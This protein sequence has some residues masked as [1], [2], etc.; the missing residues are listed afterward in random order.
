MLTLPEHIR[1]IALLMKKE[2]LDQEARKVNDELRELRK[3]CEHHKKYGP[4][5]YI[6]TMEHGPVEE[7]KT[8]TCVLCNQS[9]TEYKIV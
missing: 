7:V 4:A 1:I 8:W 5:D 3:N 6:Q 2:N 9:E